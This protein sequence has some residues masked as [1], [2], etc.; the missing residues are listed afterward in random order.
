MRFAEMHPV[1]DATTTIMRI[2]DPDDRS[3]A[4]DVC[5]ESAEY[6]VG[7]TRLGFIRPQVPSGG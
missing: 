6:N 4:G 3:L 1:K 2:S 5:V 7:Q